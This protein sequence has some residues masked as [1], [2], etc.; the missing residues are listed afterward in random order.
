MPYLMSC[1]NWYA[2]QY[3]DH[4]GFDT[5]RRSH[6]WK[7]TVD[8]KKKTLN[9]PPGA[10]REQQVPKKYKNWYIA[11]DK[12]G[13]NYVDLMWA[14]A[15]T[16]WADKDIEDNKGCHS[17]VQ[18]KLKNTLHFSDQQ[19]VYD[20]VIGWQ[21]PIKSIYRKVNV[22]VKGIYELLEIT[23]LNVED[24]ARVNELVEKAQA[25]L[26]FVK[27]DGSWG[28]HGYKYT[29]RR[30]DAAQSYV[31]MAQDILQKASE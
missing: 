12:K 25:T 2:V 31:D 11:K 3:Q 23:K 6:I 15:K 28:V 17:I 18:S 14:C 16:S 9:P 5:Q 22:S 10:P 30:M 19:R 1:E 29:R 4:A 20:E 13:H 26:D 7:I 21:K 24:R 8:P 27:K